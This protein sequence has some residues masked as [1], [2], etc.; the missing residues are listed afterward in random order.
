M[1]FAS[2]FKN[3]KNSGQAPDSPSGESVS[4]EGQGGDE[5][6]M[7][8]LKGVEDEGIDTTP[9][10]KSSKSRLNDMLI[11]P[12]PEGPADPGQDD[13]DSNDQDTE[14]KKNESRVSPPKKPKKSF[15]SG[16][17][18]KLKNKS[19]KGGL[20][21]GKGGDVLEV[22][23]VKDEIIKFFDWQKNILF[24]FLAIFA[25]LFIL[26]IAYWGISWWG[27]RMQVEKDQFLAQDY[28]RLNKQIRELEPKIE[29]VSRFQHKLDMV[30]HL[31][32]DHIY[33]TN[34][35]DFLEKNTLEDVYFFD[36]S[37]DTN[38]S[39]NLGGR[40]RYFEVLDAQKKK[41]LEDD[42]VTSAQIKSGNVVS[43]GKKESPGVAF[44]I[45][46]SVDPEI[47]YK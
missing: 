29:E 1:D 39:Y 12:P 44:N 2:F 3:N 25:S 15:F 41:F 42:R 20:L 8:F 21:G 16:L 23:L 33:W 46:F 6:K 35:F 9:I 36:F 30:N 10:R 27:N 19:D 43:G 40:A 26:T 18:S 7:D 47:F 17:L 24:L 37:G 13:E 14:P 28:Y 32:D 5:K 22:N 45:T 31:L 11:S 38:G 4:Q 34:F